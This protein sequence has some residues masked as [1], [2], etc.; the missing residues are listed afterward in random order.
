MNI[1]HTLSMSAPEAREFRDAISSAIKVIRYQQ[2][3][4]LGVKGKLVTL[5]SDGEVIVVGDIHG[6]IDSLEH[7]LRETGFEECLMEGEDLYLLCLGDY[8]DRGPG[9]VQVL[10]RLLR[11]LEGYPGR[12]VLLRGNHEG[13]R[14]VP[15]HPHDFPYV[16]RD[17]YGS[18]AVDIYREFRDLCDELY[19]A[20]V[21][22]EKTL[23]LHGGVPV[24]L[25]SLNDLAYA[26]MEHPARDT[27][28]QALWNDPVEESGAHLS[29]RGVGRL[30]GPDVAYNALRS[31]GVSSMVRSHQSC[32][33]FKWVGDTLTVFSCR[34][35]DYGNSRA[36]YL[37][38][39]LDGA[40][41]P[42]DTDFIRLF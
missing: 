21:A 41:R 33:G 5:P 19:T 1:T 37:R 2:P 22:P 34:L 13:P 38:V 11:L 31:L 27:L 14:G 42:G 30:F 9:Q 15:F 17:A 7:I 26:N 25:N 16:L 12:V 10:M 28:V 32:D 35:P 23:F 8:I 4:R 20:A 3:P 40:L 24:G 6:D 18:E 39:P 29:P 36:A